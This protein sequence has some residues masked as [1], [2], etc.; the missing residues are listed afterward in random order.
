MMR[1]YE[2]RC[3]ETALSDDESLVGEGEEGGEEEV[4]KPCSLSPEIFC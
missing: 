4:V 3:E 1:Q 2:C